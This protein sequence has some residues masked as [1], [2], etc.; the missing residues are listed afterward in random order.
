MQNSLFDEMLENGLGDLYACFLRF[1]NES[2][3]SYR[4]DLMEKNFDWSIE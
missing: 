2:Y 1:G 4:F 3:N